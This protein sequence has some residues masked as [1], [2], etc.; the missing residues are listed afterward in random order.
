MS[1]MVGFYDLP[2]AT[3]LLLYGFFT[4]ALYQFLSASL[5]LDPSQYKIGSMEFQNRQRKFRELQ[6][7]H[8]RIWGATAAILHHL[9]EQLHASH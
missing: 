7:R 9:A 6:F 5:I 4:G 1:K 8:Y 3:R 2:T